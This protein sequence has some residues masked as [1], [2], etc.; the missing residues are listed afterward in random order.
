MLVII[1]T[2]IFSTTLVYMMLKNVAFS[3]KSLLF[4]RVFLSACKSWSPCLKKQGSLRSRSHLEVK[5]LSVRFTEPA[6]RMKFGA[7]TICAHHALM[8]LMAYLT[9]V[10]MLT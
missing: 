3:Q 2:L 5:Y 1:S 8:L 10:K 6:S 4:L 9:W 7:V